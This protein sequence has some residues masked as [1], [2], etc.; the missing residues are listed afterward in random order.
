MRIR[1]LT[2][3]P[4]R[5][6]DQIHLSFEGDRILIS[7]PNG[8]GKSNIL[9]AISFL[10]I[11]KSVRGAK[12]QQAVP[13]GGE[14]FDIQALCDDGRHEQKLRIF[15]AIQG[16][17][18]AFCN[19]TALPRVSD[20]LGI[21]KTVHFSP[22]DVSLVLRFPA[23]RRRLLDILIAQ[24]S[25]QYLRDLQLYQRV[26]AQR[27]VLLRS[28]KRERQ[29]HHDTQ[30]LEPW[31]RQ[32]VQLGGRLRKKRLEVIGAI[33]VL[34]VDYYHRFAGGREAAVVE[35]RGTQGGQ[36]EEL[37]AE[38][39]EELTRRG[40][41]ERQLGYT[42]AGPHRDDLVFK[43]NDQ[44]ADTYASEGQLKTMLIA[45]KMAEVGF[46]EQ[47]NENQPVLLLDDVFSELDSQ[48]VAEFMK[49][50]DEFD[51]VIVTTPQEQHEGVRAQFTQIGLPA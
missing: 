15:Y 30:P 39:E 31:T 40:D 1:A 21:F 23:Q 27:N 45:W 24:S 35:Y 33:A 26:L 28:Q 19:G 50:I 48:R 32:L 29:A 9:E 51:Q 3:R 25:P 44:P 36:E 17:K 13:H 22:E 10:S 12:D 37:I 34:F 2:L 49:I 5:N 6:F 14:Y 4:F 8:R 42:L 18:K 38:L 47:P 41:Q 20:V 11:G 46:L 43:L 7:G 16:G